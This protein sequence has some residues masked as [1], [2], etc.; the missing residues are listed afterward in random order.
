MAVCAAYRMSHERFLSWSKDSRDKAI[1]WEA[2]QASICQSCGTR[3][4]EFERDGPN[5]YAWD[6]AHCRG[7]EIRAQGSDHLDKAMS[8]GH[9]EASYRRGTYVVMRRNPGG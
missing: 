4:E 7:C 9:G 2:R 3:P 5:A 1:W 6:L 8:R